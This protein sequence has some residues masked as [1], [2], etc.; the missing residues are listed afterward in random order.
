MQRG[1]VL[2]ILGCLLAGLPAGAETVKC[3]A[4]RDVWLSAYQG[5]RDFNMGAAR[6]IK[7]KMYQ[8]M[9]IVDFDVSG[10]VGKRIAEA[11]LYVRGSGTTLWG[12]K[13]CS[14]VI[15]YLSAFTVSHDWVEGKSARYAKDTAGH[16]A[17][18]NESSLGKAD[19]GF[20]GATAGD[21]AF[22]N[23]NTLRSDGIVEKLADDWLRLKI[24][25]RLV[26]ALVC[27]VSYGLMLQEGNGHPKINATISTREGGSPAY[28]L[29]LTGGADSRPPAAVT[30]LTVAAAPKFATA[31]AGALAVRLTVPADAFTYNVKV[32]GRPVE[33]WQIPFAAEAGQMQTILVQDL[34]PG[35]NV[36]V[37]VTAL[38][39]AGNE[40]PV[41]AAGGRT[42]KV[43]AVP[44]LPAY[45]LKPGAGRPK[46][47]GTAKV[48][49][50][51]EV[52]KVDP[53]SGEV[54]LE[55]G[56][57]DFRRANPV[58][59]GRRGAVRLAAARGEIVSFQVAV[60]GKA[61][62]CKLRV[63][64]L[65]GTGGAI[66]A[67]GVRLWRNWYV[68]KQSEYAIPLAPGAE[69]DCP[70]A[71]NKVAG[72]TLQAV[73]VDV[74][75]PRDTR[76]GDYA[77]KVT[78]HSGSYVAELAL[79]VVVYDVAIPDEI[80]F[81]PELNVYGGPGYAGSEKFKRSHRLA[82]Y[83]RCNINRVPYSQRRPGASG[84][85]APKIDKQTGKVT[86]WSIPDENL[87]PLLDG[88]LFADNPRAG[89]PI[90][91]LYLPFNIG[92]PVDYKDYYKPGEGLL[93]GFNN[94]YMRKLRH[95]LNCKPIEQAMDPKFA[96]IFQATVRDFL[97]H[98][99]AKGWNRTQ[100]QYYLNRKWSW[101]YAAWTLDEP[102]TTSDFLALRWFGKIFA[103]AV[104]DPELF[105]STFHKELFAKGLAGMKR[106]RPTMVF[107]TDVSRPVVMGSIHDGVVG[108]MYANSGQ[109]AFPRLMRGHRLRGPMALYAYGSC[110]AI[111]RSNWESAAWCL[112][113]YAHHCDGVLPW[114]STADAAALFKANTNGL[115]VDTL[116]RG[117][118]PIAGKPDFG[119][120]VAS[121][122]VHALR[123]GA[124]DCELLRLLQLK[125]G[126]SREHIGMLVSRKAPLSGRFKQRFADQ[127]AA[128]TFGNFTS[129]GFCELKEGVLKLLTR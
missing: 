26:Q 81:N 90:P 85:M 6:T 101:G 10:L 16:G 20:A 94:D 100:L 83:H 27:R 82:H 118:K 54:L 52:T 46:A 31:E 18:W 60:E 117:G 123:R 86:D 30:G 97:A 22:G 79:K 9:G 45:G 72:Q 106:D 127:A 12:K 59:D 15:R 92:W 57:G 65:A 50:F 99:R 113:A 64:D 40:S 7:L 14:E 128:V 98:A 25:P 58:W 37:E 119:P 55:E 49:A 95:D 13:R 96:T 69:F 126:W 111:D 110:N 32:Q 66:P 68:G 125:N 43:I 115:M 114:Q 77:G 103:D 28:L 3:P 44:K 129:Q 35:R 36:N 91:T 19:W 120:A 11:W 62:G 41:A 34:E 104:N 29:V 89:V 105:T 87:G 56:A 24:D 124:Q 80:F 8:E 78:V 75:V 107:R 38:D 74:H 71:D 21:V 109:F 84:D 33:R 4:T 47:L 1:I 121:F 122:R 112:K 67:R 5:E 23:G 51:P 61:A 17:T 93:P 70:A 39:A 116:G 48:W 108:V 102:V 42:S 76:P 88:S 53:V 73:T 63:S 2:S